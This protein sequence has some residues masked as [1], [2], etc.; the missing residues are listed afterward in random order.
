MNLKDLASH[1]G[2][3]PTTVS[4]ALNGYPEVS[5]ATRKR[6][7]EAA[8]AFNYAPS[9][10]ARGLATGKAGAIGHIIPLGHHRM[11]NPHFSDFIAGAGQGYARRGLDIVMTIADKDDELAAFSRL[12][13]ARRVDGFV[14]QGPLVEDPRIA[15]LN[16]MGMPFVVH[17][18][19]GG[20]AVQ[21]KSYSWVDVDNEDA[22]QRATQHLIDLGHRRIA[23]VNG[24]E[25]MNFAMLR[26]KGF[27]T[28]MARAGLE[29][30]DDLCFADDM[31][32]AYG[33]DA[34]QKLLAMNA[35]PTAILTSS[36]LIASGVQRACF[37]ADKV[38][39]QDISLLT[40]DDAF[41]FFGTGAAIPTVTCVRSSLF[42]AGV[43][44]AEMIAD[45]IDAPN[46]SPRQVLWQ[47]EMIIGRSTGAAPK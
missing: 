42:E 39:G 37:E 11:I 22:F 38:L 40:F 31:S 28:A 15:L 29:V 33:Y 21:D 24:L 19:T 30:D 34:A 14:L 12:A 32:E 2:L 1:L 13:T 45:Q 23:L 9:H 20:D 25:F 18:R 35:P 10:T 47:A 17:G 27:E 36:K 7:S 44:V 41:G 6:V 5:E 26:R 8:S 16:D 3:S 4:R 46:S 43:A